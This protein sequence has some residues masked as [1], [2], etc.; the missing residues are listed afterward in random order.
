MNKLKI[1][2]NSPVVLGHLII[3]KEQGSALIAQG[4]GDSWT[5]L[6]ET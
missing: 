2:F 5:C 4:I 1:T 3:C 6:A